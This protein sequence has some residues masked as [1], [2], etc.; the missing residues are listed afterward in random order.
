LTGLAWSASIAGLDWDEL[1]ALYRAAPLGSKKAAELQIAFENSRF[2]CLVRDEGRLVGAGRVLSDG[3]DCAYLCD[4][5]VMPGHQGT[6]LGQQIVERLLKCSAGH[7]KII[8][9]AV[10]GKEGFYRRFGFRRMCTAMALFEDPAQALARG[11]I[12]DEP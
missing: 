8:L 2:H 5:A 1:A 9:Y 7:K 12:V 11:H 3:I 4:V 10:P 6:G